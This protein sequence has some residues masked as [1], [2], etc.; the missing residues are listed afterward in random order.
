MPAPKATAASSHGTLLFGD[1]R[2]PLVVRAQ[3]PCQ[4]KN[5]VCEL[6]LLPRRRRRGWGQGSPLPNW[7]SYFFFKVS[8]KEDENKQ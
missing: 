1:C 6:G 8:F 7:D 5:H 4:Q 3:V 2:G